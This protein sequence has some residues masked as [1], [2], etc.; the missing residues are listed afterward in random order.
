MSFVDFHFLWSESAILCAKK[1][2]TPFL[3]ELKVA[4]RRRAAECLRS[5]ARRSASFRPMIG[6]HGC[7]PKDMYKGLCYRSKLTL[8]RSRYPLDC[9]SLEPRESDRLLAGRRSASEILRAT[10]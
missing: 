5:R 2:R 3:Q 9:R 8:H 7:S 6:G 1:Y 4:I 10:A